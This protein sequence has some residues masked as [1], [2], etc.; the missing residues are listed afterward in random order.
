MRVLAITAHPDDAEIYCGGTLAKCVK[1]GD[2][3]IVCHASSGSLGHVVIPPDELRVIRANEAKKSGAL[4]G[5]EVL[6][7][8]FDDLEIEDT[9]VNRDRIA[10]VIRYANP[11]LIITHSPDDYMPDHNVVSKL[12]FDASFSATLPNYPYKEKTVAKLVPIYYMETAGG[13]NFLPTEYVDITNEIELKSEMLECHESQVVW[14][15]DHDGQD[16][17]EMMKIISAFRGM[18]CGVKYAEGFKPCLVY[19]K[20]T[21]TRLLP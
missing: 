18:Q 11:D 8:G 7:A 17:V 5:I 19:L 20:G 4:A 9:K 3:V 2:T 16:V 1:R 6:C 21:P 12:V 15:R 10:E 13:M 14:L